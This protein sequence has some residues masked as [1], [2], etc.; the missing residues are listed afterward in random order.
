MA[1]TPPR[2]EQ[3]EISRDEAIFRIEAAL[4]GRTFLDV[5]RQYNLQKLP[6]AGSPNFNKGWAGHL[7]EIILGKTPDNLRHPDFG[8]WELKVNPVQ[9]R[10]KRKPICLQF[11][12]QMTVTNMDLEQIINN[13]FYSSD[14]AHKAGKMLVVTRFVV[15][16]DAQPSWLYEV[17]KFD[18]DH[19]SPA[20]QQAEFEYERMREIV[21]STRNVRAL[22]RRGWLDGN[23]RVKW[24][25]VEPVPHGNKGVTA[26]KAI[27]LHKSFLNT[28][29]RLDQRAVEG[30]DQVSCVNCAGPC[31]LV[32]NIRGSRV[33]LCPTCQHQEFGQSQAFG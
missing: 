10:N 11:K 26:T 4:R 13:D 33:W 14:F 29:F 19:S 25:V 15:E 17:S 2:E 12:E 30:V 7:V 6:V 8:D 9:Q 31:R 1:R 21:T 27:C 28:H 20:M 23:Q 3:I 16:R 22:E 18:L 32:T 24:Q 5:A